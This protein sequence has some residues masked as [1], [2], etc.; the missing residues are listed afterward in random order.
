MKQ[1]IQTNQFLDP[2]LNGPYAAAQPG[3]NIIPML[4]NKYAVAKGGSGG[5]KDVIKMFL[6]K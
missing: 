3:P 1:L 2:F 6:R 5:V 4:V